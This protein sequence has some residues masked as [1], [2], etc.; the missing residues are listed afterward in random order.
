MQSVS[1]D[2]RQKKSMLV[3]SLPESLSVISTLA[4]VQQEMT[5]ENLNA[6]IHAQIDRKKNQHNPQGKR[7]TSSTIFCHKRLNW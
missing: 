7:G 6:L 5:V 1:N 2:E 4:S 3:Y